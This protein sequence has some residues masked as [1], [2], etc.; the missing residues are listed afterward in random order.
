MPH[1]TDLDMVIYDTY[2]FGVA[3][4][5]NKD[6]ELRLN[7]IEGFLPDVVE[8]F[9]QLADT[10]FTTSIAKLSQQAAEYF[11]RLHPICVVKLR[12]KYFVCAGVRSFQVAE[13][14]LPKGYVV[15]CILLSSRKDAVKLAK[16]DILL[17]PLV[18]S[19]ST[20]V[21]QQT[22]K[23]VGIVG[24]DFTRSMHNDLSSVRSFKRIH[25][26]SR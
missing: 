23:L 25:E 26:R 9:E 17:S 13:M 12:G 3:V 22:K 20:K 15:K 2:P 24:Q 7:R 21:A 16:A 6:I 11:V 5:Q 18:F 8:L 4:K 19:L 10:K 1:G 14:K